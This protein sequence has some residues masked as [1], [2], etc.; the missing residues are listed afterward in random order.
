MKL[1]ASDLD[2]ITSNCHSLTLE[3]IH[4]LTVMAIKQSLIK[5]INTQSRARQQHGGS[6]VVTQIIRHIASLSWCTWTSLCV[7]SPSPT[8][9][10][11]S[12][13]TIAGAR[14][15][16]SRSLLCGYDLEKNWCLGWTFQ[17][18]GAGSLPADWSL[19]PLAR[20]MFSNTHTQ[21]A[22]SLTW[23]LLCL[24]DHPWGRFLWWWCEAVQASGLQQHHPVSGCY[25]ACHGHTGA[26]VW[27]QGA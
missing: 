24:Q 18:N 4:I 8:F 1:S 16:Q 6:G 10:C 23:S 13:I 26:G 9:L 22:C 5:F 12:I 3:I 2:H 19:V 15:C 7:L 20:G 27:R 17:W 21:T 25:R 14:D 11:F